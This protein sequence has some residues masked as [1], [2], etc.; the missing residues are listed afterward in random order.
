MRV[1][2]SKWFDKWATGEGLNDKTLLAAVAEMEDGLVDARLGGHVVKK[3]VALPGRGKRGGSRTLVAYRKAD[4]AF[5]VYGFAKNERV[6]ISTNELK[7]LKL[8]AAQLLSYT[9]PALIK[10]INAGEL[11]EVHEDG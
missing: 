3:R 8:L 10:A 7:A 6:N 9:N 2:K 5:F 1:F 11:I 4:K